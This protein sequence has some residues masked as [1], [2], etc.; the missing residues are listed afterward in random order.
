MI[1]FEA[2]I[3][4]LDE[5]V[6]LFDKKG[7]L[8]FANKAGEEFFGRSLKE[9]KN[10]QFKYLFSDAKD[11]VILLEK[12]IREGRLF[13]CRDMEVDLGRTA[14]INV[15]ISPFYLDGTLEGA[16]LCIREN[17][18][19]TN[20]EDYHFDML[21]YLIGSVAHEIKNPLSGIKGA[22]QIL[23]GSARNSEAVECVNLIIKEADRLNAVLQSYLTMTR[24]PVFNRLNIHEVIEHALRVMGTT[25]KESKIVIGKSYDPS[26]PIIRGDE[27]KLLQVFI[28]LLKN[29]VEAMTVPKESK[30]RGG[31]QV[32]SGPARPVL[33]ISTRPS[34][35]YMVVYEGGGAG[36]K[37]SKSKKQRWVVITMQ[38]TGMGIP[39]DEI[40]KIFLP[41]YTK[42]DGGS[43]LG[44]ALSRK[45]IKDHGGTIKVK[46]KVG[47]GTTVSVYL[48]LQVTG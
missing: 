44:L 19:L 32:S 27:G 33:S 1:S 12:T 38:D 18:S 45:I 5:A 23:Q 17:L 9:I 21:L 29:A 30:G 8:V 39:G 34:N 3:N 28:N 16:L 20:R 22:A 48:P 31:N 15:N 37:D 26:L 42:K 14:N 2:V 40:G 43:G 46:S 4:N 25:V 41:F 6:F 35:E 47:H 10:R 7:K 13:N 24:M 36:R 11:I